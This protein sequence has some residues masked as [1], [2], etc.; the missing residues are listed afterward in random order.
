MTFKQT[1]KWR[2]ILGPPKVYLANTSHGLYEVR[3][4]KARNW[5]CWLNG[6]QMGKI[7]FTGHVRAIDAIERAY[8][9]D[10]RQLKADVNI[11]RRN[12]K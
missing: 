2:F 4:H 8:Y 11:I 12:S 1:L 10:E 9:S 6:R 3:S 7:V 5:T